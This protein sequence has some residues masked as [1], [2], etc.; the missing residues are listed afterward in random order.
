MIKIHKPGPPDVLRSKGANARRSHSVQFTSDPDAFRSGEKTFS[1]HTVYKEDKVKGRLVEAQHHKCAFCESKVTHVAYG[2]VEHFR[3]KSGVRQSPGDDLMRPGYYWLAY[4]W[5]NLFLACELCNRRHKQNLFPLEDPST[6]A[7]S[8][9]DDI[10]DED[11]FFLHPSNDEPEQHIGF[12][13]G[14]AFAKGGSFRGGETIAAL[15][16][17]RTELYEMRASDYEKIFE[18]IR[19]FLGFLQSDNLTKS[20]E[21]EARRHLDVLMRKAKKRAHSESS[22]YTSMLR[23]GVRYFE[24]ELDNLL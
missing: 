11:P 10:S 8:H 5:E 24:R 9:H 3:P 16:L 17:N 19:Y 20:E 4:E 12:R 13:K 21:L 7:R 6:R 14:V 2:D 18:P 15:G 22:Q 1:F 23:D